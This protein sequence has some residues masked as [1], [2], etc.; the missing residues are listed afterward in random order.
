MTESDPLDSPLNSA[1]LEALQRAGVLDRQAR[2]TISDWDLTPQNLAR[3]ANRLLLVYGAMLA[4]AG[5]VLFLG[6]NWD[7][8]GT[9]VQLALPQT[10]IVGCLYVVWKRG[11]HTLSAQVALFAAGIFVG[12]WLAIHGVV[13]RSGTD[14]LF[15]FLAWAALITPWVLAVRFAPLWLLWLL[16]LNAALGRYFEINHFPTLWWRDDGVF[17]W[18][19]IAVLNSTALYLRERYVAR[20]AGW[21]AARWTRLALLFGVLWCLSFAIFFSLD[22][23]GFLLFSVPAMT[24]AVIVLMRAYRRTLPEFLAL[25]MITLDACVV[26]VVLMVRGIIA[27]IDSFHLHGQEMGMA[28]FAVAGVFTVGVFTFATIWLK[29]VNTQMREP[30]K[31]ENEPV[32]DDVQTDA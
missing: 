1:G 28:A 25:A 6:L 17:A 30:G 9:W 18:L 26:L 21:L 32:E 22:K 23:T 29:R 24:V 20:G 5:I 7:D 11:I 15:L 13:F 2:Q 12:S 10:L 31:R 3:D 27:M 19:A 4:L 14:V 16:I 8:M